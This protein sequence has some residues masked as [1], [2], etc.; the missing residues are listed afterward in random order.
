MITSSP[1]SLKAKIFHRQLKIFSIFMF[2]VLGIILFRF[3]YLQIMHGHTYREKSEQN[4]I[5]VREIPPLRGIIKDRNGEPLATNKPSFSLCVIPREIANTEKFLIDLNKIIPLDIDA[6][7]KAIKIGSQ[8]APFRQVCIKRNMTRD[9]LATIETFRFNLSEVLISV[10]PRRN[11]INGTMASHILG[12]LGE[13]TEEQ[14]KNNVFPKAKRGDFIGKSGVEYQCE[15]QL[16][17]EPGGMQVE[18]DAVGRVIEIMSSKPSKSGE[19]VFLT[20]DANLQRF[21][22]SIFEEHSGAIVAMDPMNGKILALVSY[23]AFDPNLFIRGI[24]HKEWQELISSK[25]HPLQNKA[26]S[27]QY[28]P[29]SIFKIIV[30]LA[31][32]EEKAVTPQTSFFCSGSFSF[33]D[34]NYNCWNKRGHGNMKLYDAIVESCDVYFYEVGRRLGVDIIAKYAYAFGMGSPT[35]FDA[36]LERNGLVPSKEWKE[37]RFGTPWQVGETISTA[38]GQ[39][40]ILITPLQAACFMSAVFNGGMLYAPR[41]IE[42]IEKDRQNSVPF[43]PQLNATIQIKSENMELMKDALAATVNSPRG[44]GKNAKIDHIEVAG[45]TGTA[46]VVSLEAVKA[47]KDEALIPKRFR[48]HAWFVATAPKNDPK[49][50]V[51][52]LVE[53]GGGGGRIAAPIANK[54]INAYFEQNNLKDTMVFS[55][56]AGKKAN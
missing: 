25:D 55:E 36:G 40:Y 21:S 20:L 32:L 17:G 31:A 39:S 38:I 41:V 51:A 46:Q 28:P 2:L 47:Y 3:F 15:K 4:R 37:K 26:S 5:R 48:D 34:S 23:P 1:D 30:G 14:L 11:Y 43:S 19:D 35:G 10:E 8:R 7:L 24:S 29:G 50:T 49:I 54:I 12:Y 9:E 18:V 42:H 56:L 13:V 6:S 16:A 53:H 22:E 44:T 52:I 27:G 33:G 45:K